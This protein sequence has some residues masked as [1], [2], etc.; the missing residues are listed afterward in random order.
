MSTPVAERSTL[1]KETLRTPLVKDLLRRRLQDASRPPR[2]A[3]RTLLWQDPEV[4][5]GILGALPGYVNRSVATLNELLAEMEDKFT[6]EILRAFLLSIINEIDLAQLRQT[7][8]S[9][10]RLALR[11][12]DVSDIPSVAATLSR[13]AGAAAKGLSETINR[14][15]P[16]IDAALSTAGKNLDGARLQQALV[17][18]TE[19]VLDHRPPLLPFAFSLLKRR[20]Q[21]LFR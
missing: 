16:E 14:H 2:A 21:R 3:G 10:G 9:L 12:A 18:L 4:S 17:D 15:R 5:L 11:L 19:V 8:A 6:P 1:L 20:L 13:Q 7:G